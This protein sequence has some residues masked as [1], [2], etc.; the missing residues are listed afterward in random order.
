MQRQSANLY[1]PRCG[2]IQ[3]PS[4]GNKAQSGILDYR[5]AFCFYLLLAKFN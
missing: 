2:M 4:E 5:A 1:H 3:P